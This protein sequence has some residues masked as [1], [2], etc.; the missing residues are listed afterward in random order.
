MHKTPAIGTHTRPRGLW[1]N[2]LR[3]EPRLNG[4]LNETRLHLG[5][6]INT[7]QE[8][9]N[10]IREMLKEKTCEQNLIEKELN[11]AFRKTPSPAHQKALARARMELENHLHHT[12]RELDLKKTELKHIFHKVSRMKEHLRKG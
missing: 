10:E 7:A 1:P 4:E 8:K 6:L 5:R 2:K 11:A 9:T 12:M 3:V